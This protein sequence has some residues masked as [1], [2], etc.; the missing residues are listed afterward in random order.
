MSTFNNTF[1]WNQAVV[2]SPGASV[3]GNIF[4]LHEGGATTAAFVNDVD[5]YN[6]PH[7]LVENYDPDDTGSGSKDTNSI[8]VIVPDGARSIE[9]YIISSDLAE[10]WFT[11]AIFGKVPT[12]GEVTGNQ[13][14]WPGDIDPTNYAQPDAMWV[15]L[16]NLEAAWNPHNGHVHAT[17]QS[18]LQYQR[19]GGNN[20][21]AMVVAT[22]THGGSEVMYMHRRTEFYLGGCTSVVLGVFAA[23]NRADGQVLGRFVG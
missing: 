18:A 13:R 12:K 19:F 9:A 4:C 2:G 7:Y 8:E 14:K 23:N 21:P 16:Q 11:Y 3:G 17:K 1:I 6:R 15:P 5:A 22:A 10:V 20:D